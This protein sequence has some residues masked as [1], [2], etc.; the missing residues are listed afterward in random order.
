M[1]KSKEISIKGRPYPIR[2]KRCNDH[3]MAVAMGDAVH[4]IDNRSETFVQT[5][6]G[7]GCQLSSIQP[8]TEHCI[9]FGTYKGGFGMLDDRRSQFIRWRDDKFNRG[10]I[11]DIIKLGDR[12]VSCDYHGGI[13]SWKLA[14]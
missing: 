4:I 7:V 14:E 6:V 10:S 2:I 3:Q 8:V 5:F 13:F 11:C 9:F 1:Q 12:V